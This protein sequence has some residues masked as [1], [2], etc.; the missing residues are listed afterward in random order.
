MPGLG[1]AGAGVAAT[2]P[3][4]DAL[5]PALFVGA[6]VA[7]EGGSVVAGSLNGWSSR[8]I[9]LGFGVAGAGVAAC[10]TADEALP[11][12]FFGLFGADSF[13]SAGT[14]AGVGAA[15]AAPPPNGWSKRCITL[16]FGAAGAGVSAAETA[17]GKAASKM[18][19]GRN[20]IGVC[21]AARFRVGKRHPAP[22]TPRAMK[23]ALRLFAAVLALACLGMARGPKVTV[24]FYA[25]ANPRD[26][27]AFSKPVTFTNP[28]RKA[29]IEKV[30][31]INERSI[32]SIYPFQADDGTWGAAFLLDA[33]GRIDLEVVSTQRRGS[34]LVVFVMTKNGI[35]QVVD[36]VIDKPVRDGIITIPKGLTEME[37]RELTKE[38]KLMTPAKQ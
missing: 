37:I 5:V 33:K 10:F 30:P 11:D 29:F 22:K 32:K 38:Y 6:G 2:A 34:S 21:L 28:P 4:F 7:G 15:G 9:M 35:H 26:T 8:S 16:G 13:T 20:F 31:S 36:M 1:S 24:R 18:K 25:E 19:A 17:S 23:C 3:F 14:G 27:E 12:C